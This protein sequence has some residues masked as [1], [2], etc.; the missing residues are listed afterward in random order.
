MKITVFVSCY[1]LF[2]VKQSKFCLWLITWFK[3]FFLNSLV[4]NKKNPF[5]IVFW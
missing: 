2:A 4:C 1:Y 5:N 3:G